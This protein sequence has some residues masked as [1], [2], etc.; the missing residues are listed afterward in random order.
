M[1][2]T[3]PRDYVRMSDMLR[4]LPAPYD[5]MLEPFRPISLRALLTSGV[6][7]LDPPFNQPSF[8]LAMLC[9]ILPGRLLKRFCVLVAINAITITKKPC[10]CHQYIEELHNLVSSPDHTSLKQIYAGLQTLA[11]TWGTEDPII[12]ATVYSTIQ[13]C[14]IV[15]TLPSQ[16]DLDVVFDFF[17]N[18]LICYDYRIDA[19][20]DLLRPNYYKEEEMK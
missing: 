9:A 4:P 15:G 16:L 13:L 10:G 2:P 3:K 12:R 5:V 6:T 7:D 18:I 14:R 17:R 11:F 19:L 1:T 20:L 8:R